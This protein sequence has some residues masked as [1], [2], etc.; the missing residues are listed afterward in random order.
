MLLGLPLFLKN[1]GPLL[2][3]LQVYEYE[4][5]IGSISNNFKGAR[6]KVSECFIN[7]KN[8]LRVYLIEC[9]S[10]EKTKE[11][12]KELRTMFKDHNAI[13]TNDTHDEAIN[14]AKIVFVQN[15]INFLNTA[16][17]KFFS[18]FNEFFYKFKNWVKNKESEFFCIDGSAVLSAYGIRDCNDLDILHHK[19]DSEINELKSEKIESQNK[20]IKFHNKNISDI[21][22]DPKNHFYFKGI[23]FTALNLVENFKRNRSSKPNDIVD[24]SLIKSLY[25]NNYSQL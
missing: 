17:Y 6:H 24:I 14:I 4:P 16:K 1:N 25:S 15:S 12:K 20:E 10:L 23:K 18:N 3:A 7:S 13:H 2:F 9:E 21:I 22:F 8:P 19:Y 11:L 5:Y